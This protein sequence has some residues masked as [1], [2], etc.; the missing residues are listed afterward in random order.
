MTNTLKADGAMAVA[1][2]FLAAQAAGDV[3]KEG[4]NAIEA[5]V[6]AAAAI[7]MVYPHMNGLG[8]DA[9]WLIH[10]RQE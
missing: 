6:A 5:M 1:P 8:G 3:L 7:A 2:H 4:G 10:E 9:F